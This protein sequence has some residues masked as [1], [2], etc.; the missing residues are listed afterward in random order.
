MTLNGTCRNL[1]KY[2][3]YT[4]IFTTRECYSWF[5]LMMR[6]KVSI[7]FVVS[8]WIDRYLNRMRKLCYHLIMAVY[9]VRHILAYHY[10]ADVFLNDFCRSV[11]NKIIWNRKWNVNAK[12]LTH[13]NNRIIS[14]DLPLQY[15]PGFLYCE[16]CFVRCEWHIWKLQK[17]NRKNACL[18]YH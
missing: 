7:T 13:Q 11:M 4:H 18:A 10:Y 12:V 3:Y 2:I 17:I 15:I 9:I 8:Y 6:S 5:Y 16:T 14:D 1:L